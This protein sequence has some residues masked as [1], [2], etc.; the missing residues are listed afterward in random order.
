MGIVGF[1]DPSGQAEID[2]AVDSNVKAVSP[3][4]YAASMELTMQQQVPGYAGEQVQPGT[5]AGNASVRRVYTF[6]QRD[7]GGQD[8]QARGFQ[9][10]VVKGSTPYIISGS[11]PAERYAEYAPTFDR[12]IEG[13][14]FT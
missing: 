11:A 10:A 7:A 2:V 1:Q 13:F 12:V 6:T 3:E 14:R 4:L 5:T 9:L 8:H